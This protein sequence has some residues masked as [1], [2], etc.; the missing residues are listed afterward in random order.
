MTDNSSAKLRESAPKLDAS[1]RLTQTRII[2]IR[3][4]IRELLGDL[5]ALEDELERIRR[6]MDV[7]PSGGRIADQGGL[8]DLI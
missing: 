8:E 3:R 2:G 1:P 6:D 5:L 4:K 7:E